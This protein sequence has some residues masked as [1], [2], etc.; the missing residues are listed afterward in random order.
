MANPIDGLSESEHSLDGLNIALPKLFCSQAPFPSDWLYP[1]STD[2]FE[3][4]QAVF[5]DEDGGLVNLLY[6]QAAKFQGSFDQGVPSEATALIESIDSL[7]VCRLVWLLQLSY[8]TESEK[9]E[10]ISYREQWQRNKK[11]RREQLEQIEEIVGFLKEIQEVAG[12][13]MGPTNTPFLS[14]GNW[15]NSTNPHFKD[16]LLSVASALRF[17]AL[18]GAPRQA[19][20]TSKL[21]QKAINGMRMCLKQAGVSLNASAGMI[22]GLFKTLY[23]P[24]THP[25]A[26]GQ[27][28]MRERLRIYQSKFG[29]P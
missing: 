10:W 4:L 17:E 1:I 9:P 19:S 29:D 11:E 15:L 22:D 12:K 2:D 3:F 5:G 20:H 18:G 28:A 21:A 16:E 6:L 23:L 26:D 14:V 25:S 24:L 13:C 27:A 8:V 7:S